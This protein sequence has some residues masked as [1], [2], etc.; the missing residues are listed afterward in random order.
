MSRWPT[1]EVHIS[2]VRVGDAVVHQGKEMTV[3]AKDIKI[4]P[5]FGRML[6]GDPYRLGMQPVKRLL[7]KRAMP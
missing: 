7:I 5:F 3:C 2:S 6:F 4:D 1:E